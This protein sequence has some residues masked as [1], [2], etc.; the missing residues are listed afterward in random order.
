MGF[1]GE[2]VSARPPIGVAAEQF[3]IMQLEHPGAGTRRRHDKIDRRESLD[4]LFGDV[5]RGRAVTGIEGRLAAAALRRHLDAAAGI[6][7]EFEGRKADRR[8]DQVHQAGD[9][10]PDPHPGRPSLLL[11]H[12]SAPLVG[13]GACGLSQLIG[14]LALCVTSAGEVMTHLAEIYAA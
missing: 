8:P 9:E 5:A 6:L 12:L 13:I 4:Y 7:K 1:G 2:G 3:R 10:Q 11:F 14:A